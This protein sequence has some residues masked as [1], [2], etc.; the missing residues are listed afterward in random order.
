MTTVTKP[1]HKNVA[2]DDDEPDEAYCHPFVIM[3]NMRLAFGC[4]SAFTDETLVWDNKM[5]AG[6]ADNAK[7]IV[8]LTDFLRSHCAGDSLA[9]RQA[10]LA[11][12]SRARAVVEQ[13]FFF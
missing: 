5:H 9:V 2:S 11:D 13:L 4:P 6:R 8:K 3:D 12:R 1:L 10:K 7:I